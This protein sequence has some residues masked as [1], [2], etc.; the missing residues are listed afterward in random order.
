MGSTTYQYLFHRTDKLKCGLLNEKTLAPVDFLGAQV[1]FTIR[2]FCARVNVVHTYRNTESKAIEAAYVFPVEDGWTIS[3]FEAEMQDKSLRGTINPREHTHKEFRDGCFT[4]ALGTLQPGEV[5]T[6][7]VAFMM[8]TAYNPHGEDLEVVLSKSILPDQVMKVADLQGWKNAF[9]VQGHHKLPRAVRIDVDCIMDFNI[10]NVHCNMISATLKTNAT[11]L[12]GFYEQ[13]FPEDVPIM[14]EQDF[15]IQMKLA[16]PRDHMK[17]FVVKEVGNIPEDET[18]AIAMP[19]VPHF[20]DEQ[21]QSPNTEVLFMIDCSGSMAN[22]IQEVERAVKLGLQGLP[23]SVRFN[24]LQFGD[25]CK[26][27]DESSC[28]EFTTDNLLWGRS[29][30]HKMEANMGGTN[31]YAA[32]KAAYAVPI[33]RGY[34]RQLLLITDG[35]V[36]DHYKMIRMAKDN[37]HTT[38][39]FAFH[40]DPTAA[41]RSAIQQLATVTAGQHHP[42]GPDERVTEPLLKAMEDMLHPCLTNAALQYC[43]EGAAMKDVAET[44]VPPIRNVASS[45]PLIFNNPRHVAYAFGGASLMANPVVQLTA[46][47]GEQHLEW[48]YHMGD[49][50]SGVRHNNNQECDRHSVLHT[51][52]AMN[53][54]RQLT[55]YSTKSALPEDDTSEV[56]RLSSTFNVLSPLTCFHVGVQYADESAAA[57]T[58]TQDHVVKKEIACEYS[59]NLPRHESAIAKVERPC[60]PKIKDEPKASIRCEP[61]KDT[62]YKMPPAATTSTLDFMRGVVRGIVHSICRQST[63]DDLVFTQLAAGNWIMNPL[64]ARTLDSSMYELSQ[65]VPKVHEDIVLDVPAIHE[66][67]R[68][69]EEERQK[70]EAEEEERRKKEEEVAIRRAKM[71]M[72]RQWKLERERAKMTEE[73]LAAL[74]EAEAKKKEEADEKARRD[75]EAAEKAKKDSEKEAEKEKKRKEAERKKLVKKL[76][77]EAVRAQEEAEARKAEEE[78]MRAQKEVEAAIKRE[79]DAKAL[80]E[81]EEREKHVANIWATA[82][83]LAYLDLNFEDQAQEYAL[84]SRRGMQWL[85]N[86]GVPNAE[87]WPE[88]A[89]A[90]LKPILEEQRQ[91][92][93]YEREIREREAEAARADLEA[94]ARKEEEQ[95]EAIFAEFQASMQRQKEEETELRG[96]AEDEESDEETEDTRRD[97][98]A[99]MAAAEAAAKQADHVEEEPGIAAMEA[100]AE[101]N[102]GAAEDAGD[103]DPDA[104]HA[105]DDEVMEEDVVAEEEAAEEEKQGEEQEEAGE[106]EIEEDVAE[107]EEEEE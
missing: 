32:L 37:A 87:V 63:L 66:R 100:E 27:L 7:S 73:E 99:E 13:I 102:D 55:E 76:G 16:D 46:W 93:Q 82:L 60:P 57:R 103:V 15:V 50:Q 26:L 62:L 106:E 54:I 74:E 61:A 34:C 75:Q 44:T 94:Q 3:S 36:N 69:F 17:V 22:R 25:S 81:W 19:I 28:L 59:Y 77:E 90:F 12:T 71:E 65:S 91:I 52:V 21:M 30:I 67:N 80:W 72:E 43:Y 97:R 78:V 29:F 98:L 56:M 68:R 20:T 5:C 89:A 41:D 1:A 92:Q 64:F 48:T 83:A 31:M 107:D 101:G 35:A 79:E 96:L 70:A 88:Q 8:E 24:L 105:V 104:A 38:R 9:T 45:L 58:W 10:Q 14:L 40:L 2:Q 49:L 84:V 53:R 85:L 33:T 39:L 18:Y 47:F 4:A 11:E 51:V 86:T 95:R 42:I 6:T 23:R